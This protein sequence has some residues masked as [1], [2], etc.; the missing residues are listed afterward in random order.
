MDKVAI[1]TLIIMGI[2]FWWL[3]YSGPRIR[4]F[5]GDENL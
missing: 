2:I 3:I 5:S 4:W 1:I